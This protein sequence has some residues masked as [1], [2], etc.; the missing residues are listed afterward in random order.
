MSLIPVVAKFVPVETAMCVVDMK[1]LNKN[2][3][4]TGQNAC[5]DNW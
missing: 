5:G 3:T 1:L 4:I 2:L